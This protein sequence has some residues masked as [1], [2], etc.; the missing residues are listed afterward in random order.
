MKYLVQR[1]E[2]AIRFICS[3]VTTFNYSRDREGNMSRVN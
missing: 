2:S 3:Q 1:S